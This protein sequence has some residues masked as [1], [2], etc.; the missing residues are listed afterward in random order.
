M[1]SQIHELCQAGMALDPEHFTSNQGGECFINGWCVAD[2]NHFLGADL[3]Q[4]FYCIQQLCDEQ[5]T[6]WQVGRP[7]PGHAIAIVGRAVCV[8]PEPAMALLRAYIQ[9]LEVRHEV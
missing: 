3:G 5:Q 9:F 8:D 2:A 1:S 7:S 6:P 4:L